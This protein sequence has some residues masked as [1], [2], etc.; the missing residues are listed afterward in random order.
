MKITIESTDKIAWLDGVEARKA[1]PT[2]ASRCTANVTRIAVDKDADTSQFE[3]EL[4]ECVAPRPDLMF[5][6]M[7]MVL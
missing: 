4:H 2:R 3:R 5:I 6:P 7:R 1:R